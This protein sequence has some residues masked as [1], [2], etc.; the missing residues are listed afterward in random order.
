MDHHVGADPLDL[1]DLV[2][3]HVGADP[4]DLLDLVDPLV[5]PSGSTG[6]P[7]RSVR[8]PVGFIGVPGIG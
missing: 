7:F 6:S 4:L 3:H 2:D 8:V 1:L 5:G